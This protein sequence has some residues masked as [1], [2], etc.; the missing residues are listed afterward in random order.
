MD[1]VR[2]LLIVGEAVL[3]DGLQDHLLR[4]DFEAV[5]VPSGTAALQHIQRHGLPHLML[6]RLDLPDMSGLDLCRDLQQRV[7]LPIIVLAEADP[8]GQAARV[9]RYA[10]DY[11]RQPVEPA[12]LLMR[13]RRVLSRVENFSYAGGRRVQVCDFL[14]VDY[15]Q[16]TAF[17]DGDE[18]QL[19]P[20]ENALLSVLVKHAGNVVAAE[21][22]MARVWRSS[23][24]IPDR[25]ALRVH[26][27]RLR[28]K[29]QRSP[30]HPDVIRT[31]RG[32]GYVFVGA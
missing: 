6:T 21:T 7:D 20:T 28:S 22:L 23:T 4:E 26:M 10:D 14:T 27:H 17:V 16:R 1:T 11:V 9:L 30:D 15:M 13:I 31:E 2:R 19:T 25:N 32:I 5:S 24:S 18:R 12:E 3:L 8:P 29:L